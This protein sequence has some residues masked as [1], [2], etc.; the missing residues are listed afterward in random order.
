[1]NRL[2]T[3]FIIIL[4][5]QSAGF[6]SS[7]TGF[8]P[9][10]MKVACIGNSVTYGY[11][12]NKRDDNSYPAQL[13][14][15]LGDDYDV[16][17][18]GHSGATLL[19]KGHNP[20]WK[21]NEYS[22]AL[23]FQAETVII[24][25][26]LNDTDPRNWPNYSEEFIANYLEL[27]QNFQENHPNG[28]RVIICRLT[29]IFSWHHR[30]YSG[31]R[32][33]YKEI[34]HAIE[35]VSRISGVELID[36]NTP[37]YKRPD[38]FPD[39]IHP[40]SEGASIMAEQV[41]K[42]ITGNFGG[43]KLNPIFQPNM[44][45]QR[46]Q[47]FV[48]Y[49]N[50]NAH[51]LIELKLGKTKLITKADLSGN[52]SVEFP[53]QK[54]GGPY[55]IRIKAEKTIRLNKI[56]FGEVW[57]AS[58]QSNMAFPFKR[59]SFATDAL[60]D[61]PDERIHL[62]NMLNQAHPSN[63]N[64]TQNQLSLINQ[65]K[66][67]SPGTW[68]TCD[69]A[70]VSDF[71]AIGYYFAKMLADS[72]DCPIGII[73]N[74]IGG[75]NIESWIPREQIER[76][77]SWKSLLNNWKESELV[78]E[79]C[80]ERATKNIELSENKRQRHPYEPGYL[81]DA[82]IRPIKNYPIS[83]VI[84]YQGESNAEMP[85]LHSEYFVEMV[86]SWRAAYQKPNLPFLYAQLTSMARPAW[87][88]F[89]Y[90]QLLLEN[91]LPNLGMVVISDLGKEKNVHPINKRDVGYR[92]GLKA[93]EN[94]YEKSLVSTGPELSGISKNQNTIHL[95][96]NN[97]CDGLRYTGSGLKGFELA[98]NDHVYYTAAAKIENNSVV[99][100][101]SSISDPQYLRYGWQPYSEGNLFNS[102]GLTASTFKTSLSQDTIN[103]RLLTYNILHGATMKGDF[104]LDTIANRFKH[105]K[106]DL[107]SMQE[108][109]RLTNRAKK[110]DLVTELAYRTKMSPLF[111]RA[112]Y[113]DSGEYGNG[114]L[115]KF[116]FV[117]SET[118]AL[119]YTPGNEPRVALEVL[120]ELENGD[121]LAFAATHFDYKSSSKDRIEQATF[122]AE[123]YKNYPY[124]VILTGDLN[125]QPDSKAINI[126]LQEFTMSAGENPDPTIPCTGPTRKIDY[127]LLDRNHRWNVKHTEVICDQVVSDHCGYMAV[128]E[129][130]IE[131][132]DSN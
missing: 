45:Y 72:L 99:L 81:F 64:F 48:V 25:L 68:T 66:Y 3:L 19:K 121:T 46:N 44:V 2:L 98:G 52:W 75:S 83:G 132:N 125:A 35:E 61:I 101:S 7:S 109:D 120:V 23:V 34:Q 4:L 27:I 113:Y 102:E 79:W 108:V 20:Y 91:Q 88:E 38:L 93:L 21:T 50:S 70:S 114:I 22:K 82:G 90:S 17:N 60:N 54:S 119:P 51:Q 115:S 86:K 130:I 16:E 87:S 65:G 77:E 85:E 47:A 5:V 18:F 63:V 80:Q 31:T 76:N 128:V 116:S 26:G 30:F 131:K 107:I 129:L 123:R 14:V 94:V 12:I 96:F 67:Y 126:L 13:Q 112:M 127:I 1:M 56:F 11:G 89:R 104:N 78:S 39:S 124:P 29:P 117:A 10:K 28:A 32:E 6:S 103:L 73:H 105:H 58:G 110:L 42:H 49:G 9:K 36:L 24:H 69:S 111:G 95:E 118:I 55:S 62:F 97:T 41:S 122:L 40:T 71:S 106:A 84:W 43:T 100:T 8:E 53:S 92:F 37:L 33:Y 74:S 57:L 15:M 59:D